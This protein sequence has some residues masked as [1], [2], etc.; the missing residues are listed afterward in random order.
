[1]RRD[2]ATSLRDAG[3]LRKRKQ[4]FALGGS[5]VWGGGYCGGI[6]ALSCFSAGR[7]KGHSSRMRYP[8]MSLR[9]LITYRFKIITSDM[10]LPFAG[11][12][13]GSKSSY[14]FTAG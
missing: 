14:K 9:R 8:E 12:F 4:R 11:N 7:R 13:T 10:A 5:A 2:T 6:R 1:M 3:A